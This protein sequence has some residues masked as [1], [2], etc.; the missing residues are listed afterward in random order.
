M[1]RYDHHAIL[2]QPIRY[3]LRYPLRRGLILA[4]AL[5]V[6][7]TAC[8]NLP[9]PAPAPRLESERAGEP[10][11]ADLWDGTA[12]F[13]VDV[14]DT[15]LPMGESDTVL[16]D[17][18]T[19]R[20]YVHASMQSL[21]V[22][23]QCGQPVAFPGCVVLFTSED[24]GQ[25]FAPTR[26]AQGAVQCQIP[27]RSC[28]C[29]SQHDHI[30]QQQY[31]RL[32]WWRDP[33]S[34]TIDW[35]MVY[36]YRANTILRRSPD[37][38]AWSDAAEV[39]LTGIWR[40]WLMP[41]RPEEM[42][43]PHPHAAGEYDCLTGSPPG[44]FVDDRSGAPE[45]YIFVGLGQNPSSMGCYRGPLGAPPSLLRKCDHTP[46]FTGSATYGPLDRSDQTANPHFDFRTI[47]SAEVIRVGD[48]IYMLYEGVRGPQAG[49]AGDTQFALGL[50]RTQSGLIDGPWQRYAG[51]PILVDLPGNVGVGH[52]DLVV[53]DG[54]TYLYTSLDGITR[55]RLALVW[56]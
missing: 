49:D 11:L 4:V 50:A 51:N 17:D 10:T 47:S 22:I 48:E 32:A 7:L 5:A 34:Q 9:P 6:W 36:E 54:A 42:I 33:L 3:T 14:A 55:S 52:A 18:G 27:C 29:T 38:L 31:P 1:R 43:G 53:M 56:N 2:I 8:A 20:A 28:P 24:G 15:G 44:I 39:P 46:L 35:S 23:D 26:S 41:C 45:L 12:R 19:L 30:D 40:G 25:T 21:G 37:G 16:L 13:V